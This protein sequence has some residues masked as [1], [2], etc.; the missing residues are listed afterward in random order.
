MVIHYHWSS[1]TSKR[2]DVVIHSSSLAK[3]IVLM[4]RWHRARNSTPLL[5]PII[6][7]KLNQMSQASKT[8]SS[9]HLTILRATIPK[10]LILSWM[11]KAATYQSMQI[12]R[13]WGQWQA[14]LTEDDDPKVRSIICRDA[15]NK[16]CS[17]SASWIIK[18]EIKWR[19][20]ATASRNKSYGTITFRL[21]TLNKPIGLHRT[22]LSCQHRPPK[23]RDYALAK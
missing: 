14:S 20:S 15:R 6:W 17:V 22:Y 10:K 18:V 16:T 12:E 1:R 11:T 13:E 21:M 8:C 7:I 3:Q 9:C 5:T 2:W 4:A 23:D 19:D